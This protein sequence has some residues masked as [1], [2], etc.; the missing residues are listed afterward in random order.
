MV[1]YTQDHSV[2]IVGVPAAFTDSVIPAFFN[3]QA[4]LKQLGIENVIVYSVNDSAVVGIWN[5]QLTLFKL[6]FLPMWSRIRWQIPS[7]CYPYTL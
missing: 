5:K 7:A 1:Q 2:L 3:H 4:G 6:T